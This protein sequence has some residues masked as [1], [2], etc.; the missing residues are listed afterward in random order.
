MLRVG[1][2]L[3]GCGFQDGAE[4]QESVFTLFHL[5]H[6]GV[7][8]V[9]MAPNIS[10]KKVTNH[11][12]GEAMN[13]SRNVLVESARISRGNIKDI[14]DVDAASLDAV[15]FPGGYGAALNLSTYA[16]D[17]V[18]FH[19]DSAWILTRQIN[20]LVLSVFHRLLPQKSWAIMKI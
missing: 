16:T 12:T 20:R 4:I 17:G 14:K 18:H 3:S 7:E 15:I 19:V 11:L 8:T 9:C 6:P 2:V 10:Q 1:V 13:E 5:D